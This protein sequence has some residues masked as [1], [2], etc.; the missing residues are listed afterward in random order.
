MPLISHLAEAAQVGAGL[1]RLAAAEA[2][3]V[4]EVGAG[5]PVAEVGRSEGQGPDRADS[6][7]GVSPSGA[8]FGFWGAGGG[9][10]H[11]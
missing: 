1:Q 9:A 10:A 8:C 2:Q 3:A 7:D 6:A 5:G 11:P 4:A